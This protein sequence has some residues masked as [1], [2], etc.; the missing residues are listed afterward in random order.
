M[1]EWKTIIFGML[2]L[3]VASVATSV[4]P[5][6]IKLTSIEARAQSAPMPLFTVQSIGGFSS[7]LSGITSTTG[8]ATVVTDNS[9]GASSVNFY[10]Q[11]APGAKLRLGICP[12]NGIFV[13]SQV[14]CEGS[15]AQ[16]C[17]GPS[18]P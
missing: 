5:Y 12:K 15:N 7:F 1:K 14:V 16:S 11:C 4:A 10:F 9:T 3:I 17:N 13:S 8:V 2:V 6:F 18:T